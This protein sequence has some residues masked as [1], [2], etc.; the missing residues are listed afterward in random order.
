M[1]M[2]V[3]L[4]GARKVS[5]DKLLLGAWWTRERF[6]EIHALGKVAGSFTFVALNVPQQQIDQDGDQHVR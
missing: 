2:T 3:T 4:I 5:A 6:Q 1:G